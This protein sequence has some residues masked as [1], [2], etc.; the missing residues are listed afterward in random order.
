MNNISIFF[1][2]EMK[3][4]YWV[5]SKDLSNRT[6]YTLKSDDKKYPSWIMGIYQS[7]TQDKLFFH[8]SIQVPH[9]QKLYHA[10]FSDSS[11]VLSETQKAKMHIEYF[12]TYYNKIMQK[13]SAFL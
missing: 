12:I 13:M 7:Y 2:G 8:F 5:K 4:Y 1:D 10:R 3:L 11:F 9:M 6:F